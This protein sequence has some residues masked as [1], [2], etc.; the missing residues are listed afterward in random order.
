MFPTRTGGCGGDASRASSKP[1]R[2]KSLDVLR[3]LAATAVMLHHYTQYYDVLYAG[4]GPLPFTFGD[5]HF[6][7]ELF[8]MLSGFVILMT[9]ERKNSLYAFVASRAAR[10]LPAFWA[11]AGFTTLMLYLR[12]MPPLIAPTVE[13]ILANAT[14]APSLF[15]HTGIDM[16]YWTLTYELVFY[17]GIAALFSLRLLKRIELVCLAWLAFDVLLLA[18]E[19]QLFRRLEIVL[20]IRYANFFIIGICLYR[21]CAGRATPLTYVLL[22]ASIAVTLFGGG[23]T[24]FYTPGLQYFTVTLGLAA[25][26]WIAARW[27]PAWM[28]LPPLL[29]LGR[30]SYSLYLIHNALGYEIMSILQEAGAPPMAGVA[31]ASAAALACATLLHVFFEVPGQRAV[32]ALFGAQRKRLAA[33]PASG[34]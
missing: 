30:I 31:V 17:V 32:L 23:E 4:R 11:A 21:I 12:P 6:G 27:N 19:T 20:L 9:V 25:L 2:I 24:A 3:G 28:N 13:M 5:G 29:Y 33:A 14:M 22:P 26:V 16:P 10:L 34:E 7:V 15:N 18:T 1:D 8:F